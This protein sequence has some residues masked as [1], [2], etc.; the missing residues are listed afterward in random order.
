MVIM[1]KTINIQLTKINTKLPLKLI[2][3]S[4]FNWS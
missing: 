4:E 3:L 2:G 1:G